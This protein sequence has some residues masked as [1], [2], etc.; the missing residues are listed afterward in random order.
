MF[1][2]ICA[3]KNPHSLH[4]GDCLEVLPTLMDGAASMAL[5]DLPYGC[6]NRSSEA[7]KWD[8]PIP[9][10]PLW[11]ELFR[12][13][14]PDGAIVLFSQG[15]FTAQLIMS[16]PKFFRYSLVWCKGTRVSGFLNANRMP[17]RN[18]EDILVFYQ[19]QPT[20]NPQMEKR[21]EGDVIHSRGKLENP[22]TNNC[23][24][25]RVEF[26]STQ[27]EDRFPRSVLTF[28]PPHKGFH[29][30]TEKPVDLCRW[31]IRTYTNPGEVVLDCTM[32]SG[33]TGVAA[34]LEK[35]RFIGVEKEQKYFDI[36]HKR[37]EEVLKTPK[38]EELF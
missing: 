31:L 5:I 15:I 17:L 3:M 10:K 2:I 14:K 36:A 18:H 35:R 12:V 27:R 29:H 13:V 1:A 19:R 34:T 23:Y 9:L 30:P 16:Q 7:G 26:Q 20:Y 4:L 28:L 8:C 32:G 11:R 21:P 37:I 25:K 6:L 33:T 38:Q 24:G 22:I